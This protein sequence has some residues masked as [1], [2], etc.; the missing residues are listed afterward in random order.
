[1]TG[2]SNSEQFETVHLCKTRT[3]RVLFTA[4]KTFFSALLTC[5]SIQVFQLIIFQVFSSVTTLCLHRRARQRVSN[6][7]QGTL[8]RAP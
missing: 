4:T 7:H 1:M 8:H 5:I 2:L 3:F 6:D